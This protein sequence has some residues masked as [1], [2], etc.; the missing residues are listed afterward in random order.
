MRKQLA[1]GS[2]LAEASTVEASGSRP[3]SLQTAAYQTIKNRILAGDLATGTFL[4]EEALAAELNMSRT[5]VRQAMLELVNRGLLERVPGRGM[6]VS[7]I[8][9]GKMLDIIE[10]QQCL[11]EWCIPHLF[12]NS[13][14]DLTPMLDAFEKQLEGVRRNDFVE[15]L[16]QARRMDI[17]LT[18]LAG[19]QQMIRIMKEISDLLVHAASQV[20]S[21]PERL[22][23]AV[24]EHEVIINALRERDVDKALAAVRQHCTGIRQRLMGFLE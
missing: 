5:P 21:S 15:V 9:V 22:I 14:T 24:H 13:T 7:R 16:I 6:S 20:L 17:A 4:S 18:E 11:L 10:L 2:S 12:K 19:N 1:H 8:D 3:G 23:K